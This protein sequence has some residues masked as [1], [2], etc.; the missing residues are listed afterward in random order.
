[1]GYRWFT[2]GAR[3]G[4]TPIVALRQSSVFLERGQCEFD[5]KDIDASAPSTPRSNF[6]FC[7]KPGADGAGY[8]NRICW[9]FI[10]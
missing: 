7:W 3:A 2:R 5:A 1:L 9:R 4:S 6:R 10:D 8:L